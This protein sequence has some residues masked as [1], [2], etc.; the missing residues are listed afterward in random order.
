LQLATAHKWIF[1]Q[2][3]SF[4]PMTCILE[5]TMTPFNVYSSMLP[6]KLPFWGL[7]KQ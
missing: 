5:V 3:T 6:K 4:R 2:N 7:I 1:T